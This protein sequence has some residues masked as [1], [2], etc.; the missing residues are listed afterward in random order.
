MNWPG[1]RPS[2]PKDRWNV[3][4]AVEPVDAAVGGVRDVD[5]AA[6]AERQ[7]ARVLEL[8][9]RPA[10]GAP[11]P[12]QRA[13][14][15]V[16]DLDAVVV[17]VDGVEALPVDGDVPGAVELP[18]RVAGTAEPD[19]LQQRAVGAERADDVVEAVGDVEAVRRPQSLRVV[20]DPDADDLRAGDARRRPADVGEREA[21][22]TVVL[23]VGDPELAVAD[24]DAALRRVGDVAA[25][26]E[27]ELAR[28]A[29]ELAERADELA[30]GREVLDAVVLGVGGVERPVGGVDR[31][32]DDRAELAVA[33]AGRAEDVLQ[34]AVGPEALD[35][36]GVLVA[37]E[38]APAGV[39]GD[40]LRQAQL[41]ASAIADGDDRTVGT[42]VGARR[43]GRRRR[44]QREAD[45]DEQCPHDRLQP[46]SGVQGCAKR[47]ASR[48]TTSTKRSSRSR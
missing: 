24:G 26:G 11:G 23:D 30:V 48:W 32:A 41:A 4:A 19:R 45:S 10:E 38:D 1:R 2:K 7:R 6:G 35:R 12:Q 47:S 22:D 27:A 9:G 29:A 31:Q 37:D 25:V 43:D 18:R 34:R 44:E 17:V 3:A 28:P 21:L 8:A 39:D 14:A 15:R 5:R 16:E 13:A 46:A 36:A 33:R 40:G 42:G 20:E